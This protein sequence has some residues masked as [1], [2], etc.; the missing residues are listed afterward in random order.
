[1]HVV[2]YEHFRQ[3]FF[4]MISNFLCSICNFCSIL[5][6]LCNKT[7]LSEGPEIFPDGILRCI[8]VQTA[9]KDLFGGLLLHG[10]RP[11]GVDHTSVQLVFLLLQHLQTHTYVLSE[12]ARNANT[13]KLHQRWIKSLEISPCIMLHLV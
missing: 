10:H 1:M 11:L 2:K 4:K 5:V 7:D 9:D 6:A 13:Q 8:W 12:L 3:L